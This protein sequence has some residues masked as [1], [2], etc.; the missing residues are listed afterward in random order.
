MPRLPNP[1]FR[2]HHLPRDASGSTQPPMSPA[3]RLSDEEIGTRLEGSEWE[4]EDEAIV[5][6]WKLAD[7]EAAMAFA[8]RVAGAAE[9]ANHHPDILIHGWNRVRLRLTNHSASGLTR[10]DFELARTIDRLTD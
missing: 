7:F 8:N 6:E 9:S 1:A 10:E 4:R 3:E 5:R 2:C